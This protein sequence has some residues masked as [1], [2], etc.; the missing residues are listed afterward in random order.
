MRTFYC[1]DRLRESVTFCCCICL[2]AF[3]LFALSRRPLHSSVWKTIHGRYLHRLYTKEFAQI[4]R[5]PGRW[6]DANLKG[7]LAIGFRMTTIGNVTC[8]L[9]VREESCRPPVECQVNV[10]YDNRM[11]LPWMHDEIIRELLSLNG[12]SPVITGKLANLR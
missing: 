3:G 2:V 12:L 6:I 7:A 4:F 1:S 10:Y 11:R 9:G 8:G 5:M